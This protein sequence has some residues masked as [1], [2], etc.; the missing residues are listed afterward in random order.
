MSRPLRHGDWSGCG[1]CAR[2]QPRRRPPRYRRD[3]GIA[4]FRA[5]PLYEACRKSPSP[6]MARYSMSAQHLGVTQTVLRSSGAP[7]GRSSTASGS[8]SHTARAPPCARSPYQPCRRTRGLPR[9]LARCN[10]ATEALSATKPT[11]VKASR[12]THLTF[13][14][15]SLRPERYGTSLSLQTRPSNPIA[16]ARSKIALPSP[17][18]CALN[19]I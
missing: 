3:R 15:V 7:S 10:A 5:S 9:R 17:S 6:V 12:F 18:V 2:L 8:G 16:H 4:G 19:T 1:A 14:Q 11:I 13:N